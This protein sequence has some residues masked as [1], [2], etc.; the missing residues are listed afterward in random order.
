MQQF[1]TS[2]PGLSPSLEFLHSNSAT[3]HCTGKE[4]NFSSIPNFPSRKPPLHKSTA[5][6]SLHKTPQQSWL[7]ERQ[8]VG[9]V[10]GVLRTEPALR[11]A[12]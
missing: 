10:T 3:L 9:L 8:G 6:P 12:R 5:R 7:T 1:E 2:W 4:R 11:E